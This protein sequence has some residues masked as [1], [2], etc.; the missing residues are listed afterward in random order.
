MRKYIKAMIVIILISLPLLSCISRK[1]NI[2]TN[3]MSTIYSPY[4]FGIRNIV[5][6]DSNSINKGTRQYKDLISNI[7]KKYELTIYPE[8][9]EQTHYL[10]DIEIIESKYTKDIESY[11]SILTI[12]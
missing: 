4:N 5:M 11:F 12:M 8:P 1:N 3:V 10:I 7:A 9:S 6:T 2:D